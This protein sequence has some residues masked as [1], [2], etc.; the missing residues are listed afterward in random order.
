MSVY[1]GYEGAHVN[2]RFGSKDGV[3]GRRPQDLISHNC[4][5]LRLPTHGGLYAW[6]FDLSE[7][8]KTGAR[9]FPAITSGIQVGG[10]RRPPSRWWSRHCA[11]GT[12]RVT[13]DSNRG[14]IQTEVYPGFL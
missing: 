5:N 2:V 6:E 9:P 11:I 13:L 10:N 12:E 7:R 8:S 3:I 4:I 14:R 1:R